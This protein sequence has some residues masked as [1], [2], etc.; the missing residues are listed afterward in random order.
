MG[1][2][3]NAL[4]SILHQDVSRGGSMVMYREVCPEGVQDKYPGGGGGYGMV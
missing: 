4:G 2:K 1:F 3:G